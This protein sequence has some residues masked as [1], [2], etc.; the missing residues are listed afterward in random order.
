MANFSDYNW[1]ERENKKSVNDSTQNKHANLE[2]LIEK[3]SSLDSNS[4]IKEFLKLTLEKKQK[5]ELNDSELN[6]IAEI[7]LPY[8][9]DKQKQSLKSL[10]EVVKN[11]WKNR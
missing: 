8:L 7:I 3:Y 2:Q 4:L 1:D 6:S 9:D 5:G 11:V 10:M